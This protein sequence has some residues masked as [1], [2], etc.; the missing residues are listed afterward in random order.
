MRGALHYGPSISVAAHPT[1]SRLAG[2]TALAFRGLLFVVGCGVLAAC[3]NAEYSVEV[4]LPSP[5]SSNAIEEYWHGY[6]VGTVSV[7]GSDWYGEALVTETGEL[8]LQ[9]SADPEQDSA[10]DGPMMFVGRVQRD[11]GQLSGN[12][13]VLGQACASNPGPF[14]TAPA[15]GDIRITA[16]GPDALSGDIRV[17]ANDGTRTWTFA[18]YWPTTTYLRPAS[19]VYVE[20]Q[21]LE[22]L[23]EFALT[24]DLAIN[25]DAAGALFFQSAAS[26]CIGNGS[27]TPHGSGHFNVYDTALSIEGCTGEYAYLNGEFDGLATRS[28]GA[29]YEEW[30]SWLAMWLSSTDGGTSP[31]S[32]SMW[33]SDLNCMGCW[34]Y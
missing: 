9:V 18:M 23:A 22:G 32:L 20:G 34:D 19:M 31:V 25:I 17:M 4:D 6:Y 8:R 5:A 21:Y 16:A 33:G 3:D 15:G 11:A 7:D 13:L 30:G 12:G 27:I 2:G 10:E 1:P 29:P 14:C 28:V 26:G 24:E